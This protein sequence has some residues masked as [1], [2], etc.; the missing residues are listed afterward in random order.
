MWKK[1]TNRPPLGYALQ[2]WSTPNPQGYEYRQYGSSSRQLVDFEGLA[3]VTTV[4]KN[5]KQGASPEQIPSDA[6]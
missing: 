1:L 2:I 4:K 5:R 3:L 6:V